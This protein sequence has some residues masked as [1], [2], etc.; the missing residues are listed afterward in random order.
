MP[1]ALHSFQVDPDGKIHLGHVF[2]AN[3]EDAARVL[4][5]EHAAGCPKFGPAYRAK[6][7]IE[8]FED[9]DDYPEPDE[10]ELADFLDL[11]PEEDED[12]LVEDEEED[13]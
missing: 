7:T 11:D 12:E 5:L 1:V 10:E 13:T 6:Q 9:I 4:L 3:D 8:I 2:Y